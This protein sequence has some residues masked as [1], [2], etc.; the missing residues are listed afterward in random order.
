MRWQPKS[1]HIS[2]RLTAVENELTDDDLITQISRSQ[3]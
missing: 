2:A 1:G 3:L